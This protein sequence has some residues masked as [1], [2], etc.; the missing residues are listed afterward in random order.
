MAIPRGTLLAIFFTTISYIIISGTIGRFCK[1]LLYLPCWCSR[2]VSFGLYV[3]I[4]PG[5]CVL[6]DASGILNDSLSL[7]TSNESC[8]GFACHYGW[9][10]SDCISNKS[11]SYGISN[12]YQVR[13]VH[14]QNHQIKPFLVRAENGQTVTITVRK[15]KDQFIW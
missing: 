10:F 14:S 13:K 6:R 11:C 4:F 15:R 5:S 7:T 2:N 8:T 12:Y 1:L 9:D 3:C